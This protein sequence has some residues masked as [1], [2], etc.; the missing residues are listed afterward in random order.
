MSEDRQIPQINSA[1]TPIS[2]NF[3]GAILAIGCMAICLISLPELRS[4]FPIALAVGCGVAF[5][6]HFV[7]P[8]PRGASWI[9]TGTKK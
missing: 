1:K 2:G 3:V 4:T 5:I 8:K 6:L 7:R 9:L